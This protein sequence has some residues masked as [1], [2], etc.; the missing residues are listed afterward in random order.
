VFSSFRLSKSIIHATTPSEKRKEKIF[1]LNLKKKLFLSFRLQH[2]NNNKN[3]LKERIRKH[4][5]ATTT[6]TERCDY[7]IKN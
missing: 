2:C 7:K 6:M 5:K 3:T 1:L 4:H